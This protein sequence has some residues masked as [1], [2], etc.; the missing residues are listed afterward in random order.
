[1]FEKVFDDGEEI[2]EEVSDKSEDSF[3]EVFDDGE[4]I[5]EDVEEVIKERT[6]IVIKAKE[7]RIVKEVM[8]SVMACDVSPVAMFIS[9]I[10]VDFALLHLC[11]RSNTC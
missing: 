9:N 6:Y 10:E 3:G 1:M 4:D 7:V 8:R 5:F 11:R 2:F